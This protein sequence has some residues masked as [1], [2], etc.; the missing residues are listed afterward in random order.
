MDQGKFDEAMEY[1]DK[2]IEVDPKSS[3]PYINK[4]MPIHLIT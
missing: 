1:L 2:A 3:L 4:G